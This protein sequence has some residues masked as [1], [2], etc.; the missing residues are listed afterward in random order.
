MKGSFQRFCWRMEQNKD[1]LL[2][3][4]LEVGEW[5]WCSAVNIQLC[6]GWIKG[7]KSLFWGVFLGVFFWDFFLL[8]L[9]QGKG[10]CSL[11]LWPKAALFLSSSFPSGSLFRRFELHRVCAT[12][13]H[14]NS[15]RKAPII[16]VPGSGRVS[17]TL[18]PLELAQGC[19][20][21]S[22]PSPAIPNLLP[23][24]PAPVCRPTSFSE[25]LSCL[26]SSN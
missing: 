20:E 2:L 19:R 26:H 14:Q 1:P 16:S 12:R 4:G 5:R 17:W 21:R 6:P 8:L 10:L 24:I 3:K 15:L 18:L 11:C 22:F 7:G 23:M 25:S 9:G 13:V